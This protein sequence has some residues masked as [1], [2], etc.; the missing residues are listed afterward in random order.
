MLLSSGRLLPRIEWIS[1][2]SHY[3]KI[4]IREKAQRI[5]GFP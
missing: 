3:I 5:D 1:P 2:W 4:D